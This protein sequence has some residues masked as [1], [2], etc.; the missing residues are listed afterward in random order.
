LNPV[1]GSVAP[2]ACAAPV[3][4]AEPDEEAVLV[5]A[6]ALDEEAVA[7]AELGLAEALWVGGLDDVLDGCFAVDVVSGSTY[8]WSPAEVPVPDASAVA[9]SGR[10]SAVSATEQA[11]I[12]RRRRTSR[13]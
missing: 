9:A 5:V 1:Y 6:P 7:L 11:K 12:C 8:C 10:P 3:P 13:Y 4:W 2:A